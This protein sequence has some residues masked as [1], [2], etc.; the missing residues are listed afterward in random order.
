MRI[1]CSPA[2]AVT[3]ILHG[4]PVTDPYRWLEDQNSLDTRAWIK[5]QTRYARGYLDALRNRDCIRTRVR[6]LLDVETCGSFL[7]AGNRLVFLKRLPGE[8][9]PSIYLREGPEGKDELLIDP[10]KRLTG[11]YTALKPLHLSP[12]G[13]LLLC[14]VKQGGERAASFEIFDIK[15]RAALSDSLPRGYLRGFAFAPDSKSFCYV[16]EPPGEKGRSGAT[17]LHHVLGTTDKADQSFFFAGDRAVRL[18]MVSGEGILGLLLY[19]YLDKTYIDFYLWTMGSVDRPSLVLSNADYSF[20]P[21]FFDGRILAAVNQAAPNRKIVETQLEEHQGRPFLDL[22]PETD[23]SISNWSV[24]KSYIVVCY[25]RGIKSEIKIFDSA[26]SR[27]GQIPCGTGETVRVVAVDSRDDEIVI[28]RES[29]TRPIEVDQFSLSRG[30]FIPVARRG[31]PFHSN[32]YAR[33]VVAFSAK[34]GTTIPMSLVGRPE[35]LAD[36]PHPTIMTSYGGYGV[37]MT[38]QFSVLVAVLMERGCLFALPHIRGGGEFGVAWHN[39]AKRCS[40][41]VAFD[42]FLS[43]AQWLIAT[44]RTVPERLAIFGGSNSG[45]LVAVAMTQRPDLFRAVL[46][47]VPLTDMLR[48]H[49]FDNAGVWKDEFGTVDDL[50]DFTALRNYSPYH[51]VRDGSGYPATMIVSGDADQNCN[52]LH[53]RKM[54]ARLQAATCSESPILLHYCTERGHSPVLPLTHRLAALTDRLT[55]L[56]DQLGLSE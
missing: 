49:L 26:G 13:N 11:N 8:E 35:L 20:S 18:G 53:S 27:V 44:R 23:A 43:A 55:F 52:P 10:R 1:P 16:H 30:T 14:E 39:A 40:R 9:Q 51:A 28:E 29:F 37:A 22:I 42:D 36:R 38:P 56:C 54:A 4:V 6:E 15:N 50:D 3:D 21:R 33:T 7:K 5:E 41:Q 46:C 31:I 48:F 45:L 17:A 19:R 12:D 47:M 25:A 32:A 34:D 2:R 24:T